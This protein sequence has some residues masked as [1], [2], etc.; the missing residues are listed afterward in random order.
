MYDDYI[1]LV[2]KKPVTNEAGSLI[3]TETSRRD[4]FCRSVSVSM[5]ETYEA[6]AVGAHPEIKIILADYLDYD[7]ERYVVYQGMEFSVTRTYR[8][9]RELELTLERVNDNAGA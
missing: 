6:L 8:N 9:G 5:K 7:F 1:T 2:K 3:E 4:V